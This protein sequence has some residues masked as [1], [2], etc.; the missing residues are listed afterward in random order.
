[1]HQTYKI[2]KLTMRNDK[3]LMALIAWLR[4]RSYN[5]RVTKVRVARIRT[6]CA[7]SRLIDA[8]R[9]LET[10][11]FGHLVLGRRGQET[12]FVWSVSTIELAARLK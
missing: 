6:G 3:T 11:G 4:S 10:L 5:T 9:T 12:R 1:M 8:F 2:L 7:R